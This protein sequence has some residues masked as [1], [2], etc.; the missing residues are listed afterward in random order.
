[1]NVSAPQ[2]RFYL[3]SWWCQSDF[4]IFNTFTWQNPYQ[5]KW[6]LV[7]ELRFLASP[8]NS[9]CF[10][11]QNWPLRRFYWESWWCRRGTPLVL[12]WWSPKLISPDNYYNGDNVKDD[13]NYNGDN[14]KDDHD[15]NDND[16]DDLV[17]NLTKRKILSAISPR[18]VL[19]LFIFA[20]VFCILYSVPL[21][22]VLTLFILAPKEGM[23]EHHLKNRIRLHPNSP[24][25]SHN[26]NIYFVKKTVQEYKNVQKLVY[27]H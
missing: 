16:D 26:P 1:M 9:N 12:C 5:E 27:K 23:L 3:E 4:A 25:C 10:Q 20:F 2:R 21:R 15:D 11:F 7:L 18:G 13:H 17:E 8:F 14:V 19:T 22:G 24:Q 6:K